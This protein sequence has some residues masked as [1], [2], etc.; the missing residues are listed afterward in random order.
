MHIALPTGR[1]DSLLSFQELEAALLLNS[2]QRKDNLN[3]NNAVNSSFWASWAC[4][5]P[6]PILDP[7]ILTRQVKYFGCNIWITYPF[8]IQFVLP[9][10]CSALCW[11]LCLMLG[12]RGRKWFLGAT[13]T[14]EDVGKGLQRMKDFSSSEIMSTKC[15]KFSGKLYPIAVPNIVEHY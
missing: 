11:F 2:I 15:L 3:F 7:N 6:M 9:M 4:L 5:G 10:G 1:L 13:G 8:L 14:I 12:F